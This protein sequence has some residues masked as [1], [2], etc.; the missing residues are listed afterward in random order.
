ML[1]VLP[2]A[3]FCA[4]QPVPQK[5]LTLTEC[6]KLALRQSEIIAVDSERIREAEGRFLQA[7]GTVLPHVSFSHLQQREQL[8]TNSTPRNSYEQ[9][10]VF[11]QNLFQGFKE[12]AG[13]AGGHYEKKQRQQELLRAKQLLF[14]D[15]SDAFYLL[16]ETREDRRTL[17]TI[18]RAF[19]DRV[20]E[21]KSRE[22]LGK[23]RRSEVVSTETQLYSTEDQI[24]QLKSQEEIARELLEFLIGRPVGEITDSDVVIALRPEPAYTARAASRADVLAQQLAWKTAKEGATVAR[25]NFLPTVTAEGDYFTHRQPSA[26]GSG[27]WQAF[28]SVNI[29]LFE[30][31]TN[32]GQVKEANAIAK[33]NELLY[34][35]AGRVA[36]QD[37]HNAYVNTSASFLRTRIL[38]K[39][40]KSAELNYD[41]QSRDYKLNVVNNLDVLTALQ[42]L[43]NARRNYTRVS[44]ES[45]RFYW[46]LQ[47]AAGEINPDTI[48]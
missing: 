4:D 36:E 26:R 40:L 19:I 17:E 47:T 35:R 6:Y 33:E 20:Q 5:P 45:R 30:G 9:K 37:I 46:Q 42:D 39:A 27:D 43:E 28:I 7:L 3:A 11:T 21:L 13:I 44:Y 24:Q 23:S 31:T 48:R 12:F 16:M 25:S 18:E 8:A 32:F 38:E 10:F 34:K 41:L 22:Q 29:P 15:V 14:T 2:A 1:L